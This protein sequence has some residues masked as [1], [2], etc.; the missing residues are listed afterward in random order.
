[1]VRSSYG[2]IVRVTLVADLKGIRPLN[3]LRFSWTMA[4]FKDLDVCE[5]RRYR[6]AAGR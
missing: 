6:Q 3:A 5:R 1:M 4:R 2:T